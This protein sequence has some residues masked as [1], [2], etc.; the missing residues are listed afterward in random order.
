MTLPLDTAMP[1]AHLKAVI[2]VSTRH[3]ADAESTMNACLRYCERH[4]YLVT[5]VVVDPTGEM[6][7]QVNLL[8]ADGE[9]DVV[10]VTDW[11]QLAPNRLPRVEFVSEQARRYGPRHRR[12]RRPDVAV[13]V[14]VHF[15]ATLGSALT[16]A[17]AS[18]SATWV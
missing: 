14:A 17:H 13:W 8:L 5:N 15:V 11:G 1:P 16:A 6:W 9:A 18:S 3:L 2:Y 12:P 4:G 7:R 10:V